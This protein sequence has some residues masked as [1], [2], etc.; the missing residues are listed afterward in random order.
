MV[1]AWCLAVAALV[2]THGP[3]AALPS[4]G[5]GGSLAPAQTLRPAARAIATQAVSPD[6]TAET[7][8]PERAGA[9]SLVPAEALRPRARPETPPAATVVAAAPTTPIALYPALRP[10]AR[11]AGVIVPRQAQ[12]APAPVLL[13]G[14]RTQG[15]GAALHNPN[16]NSG[17]LVPA[18]VVRPAPGIGAG[19]T[20]TRGA[21][22][23]VPGIIGETI[24]P[25]AGRV[26]GCGIANPVKITSV[27]GVRLS[28][29]ATMDCDTARA[30]NTWVQR[31]LKPAFGAANGGVTGL[32]IAGSYVCRTRN[33]RAG[34]KISEHGRGRA[35]DISGISFANGTSLSILRDYKGRQ[36]APIRAAHR[37]A[38]GI[39]GTTLGPGSDGMHEDH[40]HFDTARHRKGSYCR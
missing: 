23:G 22:C 18:A 38:C 26:N 24:S 21:V 9:A 20:G 27:N 29:A 31:G 1:K 7:G 37:A 28:Q 2:L 14:A 19:I 32:Q 34:A 16:D 36:G 13:P 25:I 12:V 4:Q 33:H 11:P 5:A 15:R 30:L 35:V 3:A 39:F 17:Q 10:E 40:L 8:A 6:V